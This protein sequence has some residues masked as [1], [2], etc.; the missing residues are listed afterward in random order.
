MTETLLREL[1]EQIFREQLL[2]NW[3]F[4]AL[5][6]AVSLV[7][8]FSSAFLVAYV[9]KRAETY[10]TKA[11]LSELIEQLRVTT[12]AAEQVK[13]AIAH[14]DWSNREWKTLRRIKLEEI[15]SAAYDVR[16]WLDQDMDARFFNGNKPSEK[17]P[18]WRLELISRLYFP[19]LT[20][21][22]QKLGLVHYQYTQWMINIQSNLLQCGNDLVKRQAVFDGMKADLKGHH[23]ALL[24]A[25]SGMEKKV[26]VVMKEIVG[27]SPE[28]PS[29]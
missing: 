22:T 18:I 25:I 21:E 11:D 23:Q 12:D 29:K 8:A 16:H 2:L 26:P 6:V 27:T 15:F 19:E 10:A 13:A 20:S 4:Y 7:A 1:V 17:S 3:R 5:L 14:A 24:D 9:R 28:T